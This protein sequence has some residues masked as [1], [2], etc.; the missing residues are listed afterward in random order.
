MKALC[1]VVL[2]IVCC[3]LFYKWGWPL[4]REQQIIG[5]IIVYAV[6]SVIWKL[7]KTDIE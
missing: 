7:F 1:N 5:L 6:C 4:V 3:W 2:A